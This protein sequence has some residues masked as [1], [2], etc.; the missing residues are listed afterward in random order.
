MKPKPPVESH[1][2][3]LRRCMA[4]GIAAVDS[5]A[6]RLFTNASTA[7]TLISWTFDFYGAHRDI[8]FDRAGIDAL[9]EHPEPSSED[10]EEI[11]SF[12]H[13][14]VRLIHVIGDELPLV[15]NVIARS[16][17]RETMAEARRYLRDVDGVATRIR[18]LLALPLQAAW[19][20]GERVLLIGHSMGSVIAYDCLW[21]LSR[22]RRDP[23]RLELFITLGSPLAS[24]LIREGLRGA[25]FQGR[26][27]FPGNVRRWL[28]FSARGEMT[29]LRTR[30]KPFF[31]E[32]ESLG[33]L[34]AFEDHVDIYN[35]FRSDLGL[36][37][38]KSYGY[39]M[40][41]AVAGAIAAWLMQPEPQTGRSAGSGSSG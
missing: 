8:A 19:N 1:E 2:Q 41:K 38:H 27:R 36:N 33:L 3:E 6:G 20:A 31:G 10:I 37:V 11:D 16:E 17:M 32:M 40:N 5:A 29:A 12:R 14:V 18:A 35:H 7:L 22:E 34:D 39:L 30:L 15:G 26:H 9:L 23:H 24:R 4:A 13:K 25:E 28:N 21:E